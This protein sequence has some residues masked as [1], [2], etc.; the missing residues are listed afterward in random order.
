[1][2]IKAR[3]SSS[4]KLS[5]THETLEE[6]VTALTE[7]LVSNPGNIVARRKI[8]DTMQELLRQDAF[9]G[10]QGET[11]VMYK[12]H[13]LAEHK[14]VHPKERASL[15]T[16]PPQNMPPARAAINWLGWSLVG[17]IPSG[18]GTLIIAPFAVVAAVKL[19]GQPA[20]L[21]DRRRA[22]VVIVVAVILWLIAL[23][24][25]FILILHVV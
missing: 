23:V 19:L 18:L 9:L 1:M 5:K 22:W 15:E 11:D 4:V 10:Y 17:L 24:F 8:Y 25:F 2:D 6:S 20:E 13:T 12:I 3:P 7:V 16:F 14:F 21:I